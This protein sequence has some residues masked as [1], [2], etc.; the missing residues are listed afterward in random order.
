MLTEMVKSRSCK[1]RAFQDNGPD[2][3]NQSW[4]ES[5]Q[6]CLHGQQQ[7]YCYLRQCTGYVIGLSVSLVCLCAGLLQK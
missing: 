5:R 3:H 1:G 7:I 6:S 2:E 4:R